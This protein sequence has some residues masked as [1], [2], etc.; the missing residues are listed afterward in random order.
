MPPVQACQR[1]NQLDEHGRKEK[2]D[3]KTAL[4]LYRCNLNDAVSMP[5]VQARQRLNQMGKHGR[6]EKGDPKTA[7]NL[8]RCN[9]NYIMPMPP[10]SGIPPAGMGAS[11]FGTSATMASVVISSDAM[12]AA[13]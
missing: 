12:E 13:S 3:P 9:L 11:F 5:P 1:L 8:Y 4:N 6:K 7:L 10:M 2:G